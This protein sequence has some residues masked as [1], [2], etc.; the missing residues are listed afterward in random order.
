VSYE[1][2]NAGGLQGKPET[3]QSTERLPACN[4]IAGMIVFTDM[5]SYDPA[6]RPK[7]QFALP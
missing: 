2:E 6:I 7:K 1:T 4:K 5:L 3:K